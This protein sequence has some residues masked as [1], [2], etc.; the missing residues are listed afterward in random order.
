MGTPVVAGGLMRNTGGWSDPSG[1]NT[2]AGR[3][4]P[5]E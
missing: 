1:V 4:R 3:S 2:G 5:A